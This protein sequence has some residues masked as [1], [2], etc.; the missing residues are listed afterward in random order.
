MKYERMYYNDFCETVEE[1]LAD[2]ILEKFQPVEVELYETQKN[3]GRKRTGVT[4]RQ[5]GVNISPTIYLEAYYER[6]TNGESMDHLL[7]SMA[8]TYSEVCLDHSSFHGESF[9][10]YDLL[11][12]KVISNSLISR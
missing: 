8:Q 5:E 4:V 11:Q 3:N 6:Y 1:R 9:E 7:D 12:E 2:H 10:N